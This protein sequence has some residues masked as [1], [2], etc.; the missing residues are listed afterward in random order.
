[1]LGGSG[2]NLSTVTSESDGG[3]NVGNSGGVWTIL[4]WFTSGTGGGGSTVC[5]GGAIGVSSSGGGGRFIPIFAAN[6][7]SAY[8]NTRCMRITAMSA[9][10]FQPENSDDS[11]YIFMIPTSCRT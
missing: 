9:A 6:V 11:V 4:G 10:P 5:L 2:G 8:P 7:Y 1:M 3:E